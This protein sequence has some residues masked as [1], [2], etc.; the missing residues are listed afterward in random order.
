MPFRQVNF[1]RYYQFELLQDAGLE[2]G[3]FTRQGGVSP[4]PWKAL[5]LGG[6]VGDAPERV[7]ENKH[8]LF[9]AIGRHIGSAFEVWQVHGAEA[10]YARNPR[11]PDQP[12]QKADILLTDQ[13]HVTLLMRFADCVPVLLYDPEHGAAGLVHAGWK[14]SVLKAAAQAVQKMSAWFG[15]RPREILAGIGPSIGAHHYTVGPEVADQ[16]QAAFDGLADS[17]LSSSNGAGVQFDLWEANRLVL[18]QAGVRNIEVAELCTA[19]HPEDWFS[20]RG[21]HGQTGRFG[22]YVA[23]KA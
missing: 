4:A 19:C 13:P 20:H 17:L 9:N 6:S 11:L 1:L 14:G 21:E 12:F 7:A 2:H 15:T 10:I 5:N 23:L 3:I 16:V 22:A 18:E 8:M